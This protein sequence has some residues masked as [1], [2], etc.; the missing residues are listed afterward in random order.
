MAKSE[1]EIEEDLESIIGSMALEG[2]ELSDEQIATCRAILKGE[3]DGEAH[4]QKLL[5]KYSAANKSGSNNREA[6]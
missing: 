5:K 6:G 2:S 3:I 1:I 4:V